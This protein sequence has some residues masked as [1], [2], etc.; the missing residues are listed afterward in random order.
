MLIFSAAI[1]QC[2]LFRIFFIQLLVIA[3][4]FEIILIDRASQLYL[5]RLNRRAVLKESINLITDII[6]EE[7]DIAV[8]ALI[9]PGL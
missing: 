1:Y 2:R 5:D 7:I 9:C 8:L 3:Q 6:A 4:S